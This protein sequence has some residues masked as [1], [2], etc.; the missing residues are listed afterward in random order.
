FEVT[1]MGLPAVQFTFEV[2]PPQTFNDRKVFR[3]RGEAESLKLFSLIYHL[4]DSVESLIDQEHLY[5]H[6]FHLIQEESKQTRDSLEQ[7]NPKKGETFYWNRWH[8]KGRDLVET[9]TST[10]WVQN[11]QDYLSGMY[12]LRTISTPEGATIDFPVSSEGSRMDIV[13]TVEKR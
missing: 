2:M 3:I 12:Y 8:P 9:K 13:A 11:G 10:P 6:N 4:K 5:S 1:Y 7:H